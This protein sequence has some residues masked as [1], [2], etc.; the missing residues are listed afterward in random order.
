MHRR[1][2]LKGVAGGLGLAVLH[3]NG[4]VLA[5]DGRYRG[6]ILDAHIH[7]FDPRRPQGIPWPEKGDAI[8]GPALPSQ[9]FK[10]AAVLGIKGAIA[11]EASPWREDNFW[12]LDTVRADHRMVGFVGNLPLG[13][14]AFAQD[15]K[16]FESEP[17]FLGTRYGNLWDRD[18]ADALQK[19]GFIS[20]LKTLAASGRTLDSANPD[21]KLLR[22][23]LTLGDRVPELAIMVDHL[24]NATVAHEQLSAYT[25]DLE[26]ISKRP[27]VF[28]KLSEIPRV[29]AGAQK[30]VFDVGMYKDVLGNL[31]A[32]FGEDKTVFGSD[33]P[34]SEHLG[35][36]A[37]TVGLAES[38][39]GA[40]PLAVQQKVLIDNAKRFY[41]INHPILS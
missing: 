9:Y 34:N 14:K 6:P 12:L 41:H 16:R 40:L 23:L 4:P 2:V 11:V 39:L 5:S 29:A 36:L 24:P 17:L 38:F 31:W 21:P 37:Q 8:Y 32:L 20:D 22:D 26:E 1:T 27:R 33:W 18:L 15:Y 19:P 10:Q 35:S 25:K 7:Q 3:A 13:E 28:M 30:A